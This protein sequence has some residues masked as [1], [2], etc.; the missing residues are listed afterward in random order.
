MSRARAGVNKLQLG[1]AYHWCEKKI[2]SVI[3]IR[4]FQ[5]LRGHLHDNSFKVK[6]KTVVFNSQF[7]KLLYD[8]CVW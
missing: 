1:E 7:Y 5:S 2:D 6:R 3:N 4:T 8:L